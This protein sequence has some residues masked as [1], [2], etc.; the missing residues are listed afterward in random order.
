MLLSLLAKPQL[1]TARYRHTG[2]ELKV[3]ITAQRH[4]VP[5]SLTGQWGVPAGALLAWV[6]EA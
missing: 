1:L 6:P 2:V 5:C 3:V 4:A